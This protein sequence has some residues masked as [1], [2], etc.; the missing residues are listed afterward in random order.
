MNKEQNNTSNNRFLIGEM[1]D[2]YAPK[3]LQI[4]ISHDGKTVWINNE[5]GMNI[6]R[7]CRI[8]KLEIEDSRQG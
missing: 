4:I 6:F 3:L 5:K 7:A 8:G 1:L 2:V